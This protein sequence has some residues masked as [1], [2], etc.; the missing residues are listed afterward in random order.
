MDNM[1]DMQENISYRFVSAKWESQR[2]ILLTVRTAVI[3]TLFMR[4]EIE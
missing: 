1:E 3:I 2:K 4:L